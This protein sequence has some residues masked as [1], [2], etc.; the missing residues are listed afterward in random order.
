VTRDP[1]DVAYDEVLPYMREYGL[2]RKKIH[3]LIKRA[4]QDLGVLYGGYYFTVKG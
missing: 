4:K 1:L 3:K 2:K